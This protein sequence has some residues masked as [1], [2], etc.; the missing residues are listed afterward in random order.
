MTD[1]KA[2]QTI[3]LDLPA[4]IG[5][6]TKEEEVS[7]LEKLSQIFRVRDT[8]LGSLFSPELLDWFGVTVRADFSTDIM[9]NWR[10]ACLQN[11]ELGAELRKAQETRTQL[12]TD[13]R[14][15]FAHYQKERETSEEHL[16]RTTALLSEQGKR[17]KELLTER[18]AL[19]YKLTAVKDLAASAWFYDLEVSPTSI[20]ALIR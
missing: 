5:R 20:R 2:R 4:D 15:S 3:T 10:A 12:E 13:N 16:D 7:T 17:I 14:L 9:D 8:Y 18:D 11:M 6:I 1:T 19:D